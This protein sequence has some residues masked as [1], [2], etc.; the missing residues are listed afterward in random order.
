MPA[1]GIDSG[2]RCACEI[3]TASHATTRSQGRPHP[4]SSGRLSRHD[5]GPA[6]PGLPVE[7]LVPRALGCRHYCQSRRDQGSL[8][9][10][11]ASLFCGW[12]ETAS[13][14]SLRLSPDLRPRGAPQ[15]GVAQPGVHR[16]HP[17]QATTGRS[18][19]PCRQATRSR[20]G[21]PCGQATTGRS[22]TPHHCHS[23][24]ASSWQGASQR[25]HRP[26][27]CSLCHRR[28]RHVSGLGRSCLHLLHLHHRCAWAGDWAAC[29]RFRSN[30]WACSKPHLCHR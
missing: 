11:R 20:S 1:N 2:P 18:E 3:P 19:T 13:S 28:C 12:L 5:P 16:P 10:R 21:T 22:G 14:R 17:G 15:P 27:G 4:Q 26:V 25:R 30:P 7:V 23:A 6:Q 24:A 9:C 29:E 8:S